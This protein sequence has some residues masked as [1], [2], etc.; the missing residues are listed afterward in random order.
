MWAIGGSAG[1]TTPHD[2]SLDNGLEV[3][4]NVER[5]FTPRVSVRAQVAG[6]SWDV[7][8]RHFTG[9][10]TPLR[11]DGNVVYNWEGGAVHPYVTA[12]VGAYRYHSS[13]S[14]TPDASDTNAGLDLGGGVEYFLKGRAA[15]TVEA[16]Y[17]RVGAFNTPLATFNDGSYWS[18]DF[19]LKGYLRP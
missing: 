5:Y 13:L 4:G 2:P 6:S 9:T 3:A 7:V 10:V 19:G 14:A 15:V 17:H 1:V 12:G 16:L 8:G 18:I 11:V